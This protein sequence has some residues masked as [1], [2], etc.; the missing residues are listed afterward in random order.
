MGG[1]PGLH[2]LLPFGGEL[3]ICLLR[4][5]QYYESLGS[6]QTLR[7]SHTDDCSFQNGSVLNQCRLDF[8]RGYIL[9]A[10]LQHVVA[11]AGVD[12]VAIVIAAILV[13]GSGPCTLKCLTRT[14]AV[15]PIHQSR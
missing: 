8:K 15:R 9:P 7:I 5:F 13:S 6:R 3:G 1:E 2:E 12:V 4:L 10:H 14:V 11:A